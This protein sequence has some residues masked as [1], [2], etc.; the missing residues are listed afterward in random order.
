MRSHR[1]HI[2]PVEY[3]RRGAVFVSQQ[4]VYRWSTIPFWNS[5]TCCNSDDSLIHSVLLKLDHSHDLNI[6]S[7][8][9]KLN[10]MH[11]RCRE[12]LTINLTNRLFTT[13]QVDKAGFR[14]HPSSQ[15][16]VFVY[17]IFHQEGP[18]EAFCA[19]AKTTQRAPLRCPSLNCKLSNDR[20]VGLHLSPLAEATPSWPCCFSM[21]RRKHRKTGATL[22][23]VPV[24]NVK[25]ELLRQR[26]SCAHHTT[27]NC[28]VLWRPWQAEG[29]FST[30][31]VRV[32]IPWM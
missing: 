8:R 25:D 1:Q 17:L 18:V 31:S 26:D 5:V 19:S 24:Y 21:N 20:C 16:N 15:Q 28:L 9:S 7:T 30:R 10:E 13:R 12:R 27:A 2:Y 23:P 29:R 22:T 32:H 14:Q 6:W 3:H 11:S 4:E